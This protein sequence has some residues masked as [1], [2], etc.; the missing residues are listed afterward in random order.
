MSFQIACY[1]VI[2][3]ITVLYR[4]IP[5]LYKVAVVISVCFVLG[6]TG[7]MDMD[8]LGSGG[9]F[10]HFAII[11]VT[12]L[13]GIRSGGTLIIF[14]QAVL[15]IIGTGVQQGWIRF[16]FSMETASTSYSVWIS[17]ILA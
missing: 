15:V 11:L 12:M 5:Y 17:H 6:C 14:S 10:L 3:I 13:I 16:G 1:L 8:L 9:L 4:K 2:V 7:T